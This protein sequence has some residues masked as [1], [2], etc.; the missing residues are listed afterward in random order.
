MKTNIIVNL[1]FEALHCWPACPDDHKEV[2]LKQ[3]HRH[4]FHIKLKIPVNH[5][6]RDIE[7]IELKRWIVNGLYRTYGKGDLRLTV[8]DLGAMSCEM[9]ASKLMR[10]WNAMYVSVLEDGENGAEIYTEDY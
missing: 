7:F 9:L 5:C 8:P 4:V 2:Y 1:Q 3:P 6:D 10:E